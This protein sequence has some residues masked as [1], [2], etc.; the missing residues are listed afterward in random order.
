MAISTAATNTRV[1]F[2]LVPLLLGALSLQRILSMDVMDNDLEPDANRQ[3]FSSRMLLFPDIGYFACDSIDDH[4]NPGCL[5]KGQVRYV[6]RPIRTT[7]TPWVIALQVQRDLRIFMPEVSLTTMQERDL[8]RPRA[9]D[10]DILPRDW[11]TTFL[12]REGIKAPFAL[13]NFRR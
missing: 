9:I 11:H 8:Q 10:S 7:S 12:R 13:A 1:V 5:R 3:S 2:M 4:G 6:N